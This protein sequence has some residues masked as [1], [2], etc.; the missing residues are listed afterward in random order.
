MQY[1]KNWLPHLEGAIPV[2]AHSDNLSMYTIALEGW[3][4][5]LTLKFYTV[6]KNKNNKNKFRYSLTYEG[7]E[8]LFSHSLG[9]KISKEG[10]DICRN[11]ELT[12]QTLANAG[13]DVPAGTSFPAEANDEEII[14]YAKTIG[15]PLVIK[16]TNGSLGRGVF[17]NIQ[18]MDTFNKNLEYIRKE[19]NY[20]SVIV[21]KFVQGE[22]CRI[23]VIEN[24]VIGAANRIPANVIGDG[25]NNIKKLIELKN[26]DRQNNP[27]ASK[28]LIKVDNEVLTLLE[29]SGY[30]LESIPEEGERVFLREKSN[31]SAGGDPVDFTPQL[32]PEMKQTA[33]NAA[34]AVGLSHCGLDMIVDVKNN[35]GVVI[36][37][38]SRAHIG[39]IMFPMEGQARDVP[40]AIIDY[41]F[42]E[43][44]NNKIQNVHFSYKTIAD[45]LK[46][47]VVGEFIVP[48]A[49]QEELYKQ[50]YTVSGKVQGVGYR[51][52]VL[53]RCRNLELHGFAKNLNN[54]NVLI[55]I[56]GKRDSIEQF[57]SL[58]YNESPNKAIVKKVEKSE[59]LSSVNVGFE[60]LEEGKLKDTTKNELKNKLAAEVELNQKLEKQMKELEQKYHSLENKYRVL[61]ESVSWRIT[62]PIRI[63]RKLMKTN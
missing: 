31:L 3:R 4:R 61:E 25:K 33:I 36:E 34:K 51:R 29:A 30:T 15:F 28:R 49:P 60:V 5:G 14:E 32:T 50:S 43:T 35:R 26:K 20:D 63:I 11:K 44:V 27:V 54:G 55:V 37:V 2:E 59:W 12:R 56:A 10:I 47:G 52:W 8:H 48:Q 16:P 13:V 53:R 19:L 40:K 62:K 57:E 46:S 6:Y 22:E 23:Y 45:L 17:V 39:S 38:N 41:Y 9:D 7:R 42:P 1:N 21:E 24:E 58:I 18:D